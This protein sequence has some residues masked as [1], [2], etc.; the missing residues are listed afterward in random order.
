[1]SNQQTEKTKVLVIGAGP[2]GMMAAGAA[3]ENGADVISIS[4][5]VHVATSGKRYGN[6][7]SV[8][9]KKKSVKLKKGKTCKLGASARK[10]GTVK[11]HRRLSY[12]TTNPAVATVSSSGKIK[13]VGKGTCYIYAYTQ[14]G[15]FKRVKVTV[16]K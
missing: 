2:A 6:A 13:A 15:L 10:K 11:Q 5:K 7:T 1:M 9:V 14:N 8:S 4:K 12:E 3:A 16:K